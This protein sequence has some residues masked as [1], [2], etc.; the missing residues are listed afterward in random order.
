MGQITMN[1]YIDHLRRR[2]R[3]A[4]KVEK[5]LILDEFCKAS[6]YH[7]KSATRLLNHAPQ[8]EKYNDK[9]GRPPKYDH[10]ELKEPLKHIWFATDQL[11]GKL[12]KESL[13]LWLDFYE[14]HYGSLSDDIKEQLLEISPATIDRLL[15]KEKAQIGKGKSGT[16]PG[17]LLKNQIPIKTNQW[18]EQQVGFVEADTVAHCGESLRGDFVWSLTLTDIL[19]GWT[20]NRAVWNK[21]AVGVLEQIKDIEEHLPFNLK[22]FDCDNGSEFLNY[23]LLRYFADRQASSSVQFTRSRPYKKNDNAHVEQKNW[24]R[25]RQVFGYCRFDNPNLIPLMNDIYANELNLLSNFFIPSVKLLDKR[26]VKSRIIKKFDK[27]KTPYQRLIESGCLT[28]EQVKAL[29]LKRKQLDPFELNS[30]IQAKLKKIF[31]LVNQ[32]SRQKRKAI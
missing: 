32:K 12:L 8:H 23:H 28:D 27:P 24:T 3:K 29:E 13:P 14:F 18:D 2:Y 5:G 22:G 26:R 6:D 7:R 21:G 19:T 15:K 4:G 30:N 10:K 11:C 9:G 17:S 25:V 1:L 16:K 20:E 31:R